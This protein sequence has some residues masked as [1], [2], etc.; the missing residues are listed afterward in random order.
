[1]TG[2]CEIKGEGLLIKNNNLAFLFKICRRYFENKNSLCTKV[3]KA[4][5]YLNFF[6]VENKMEKIKFL[7]LKKIY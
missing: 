2:R 3:I 6:F 1:M 5:Y 4:R 7:N